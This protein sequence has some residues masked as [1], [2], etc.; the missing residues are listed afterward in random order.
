MASGPALRLNRGATVWLTGLSGA[1]KSTLAGTVAELVGG[2]TEVEVLDGD[3]IRRTISSDLG[4]SRQDRDAQGRR[5][6]FIAELLTR[7]RVLTLVPV[8]APYAETRDAVRERHERNGSAFL[9]VY[10]STP[11]GECAR[12]DPKGLYAKAAS[13]EITGL[14]GYDDVYEQPEHPDL[15]LDTTELDAGPSAERIVD[16]LLER[17]VLEYVE[18]PVLTGS[19]YRDR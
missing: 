5:V 15:R 14:T 3:E 12:R 1:G 2:G 13:G 19:E 10:V 16:L 17:G 18:S 4:F 8:I 9:E 7:H 6:G 11:L